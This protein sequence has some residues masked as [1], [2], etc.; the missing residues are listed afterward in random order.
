LL[1]YAGTMDGADFAMVLIEDKSF[2]HKK[3]KPFSEDIV[4]QAFRYKNLMFFNNTNK[5]KEYLQSLTFINSNL[6]LMSSGNFGG[7]NLNLFAH[8]LH[9]IEL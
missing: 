3:M 4:I 7:I 5:I 8:Q 1:E 6:L 9:H 2:V